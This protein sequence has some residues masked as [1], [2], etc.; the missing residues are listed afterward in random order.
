MR[1][2]KAAIPL[3]FAWSSPFVRW[4]GVLSEMSSLDLAVDVTRRALEDRGLAPEGIEKLVLGWTVPQP[5]IFYGAPTVAARIGAE[6]VSGPMIS[7]ACATS[8]VCVETAAMGVEG[9]DGLTLV[10]ATDRTSNGP[11]L[12]YPRPSAMGGAPLIENWVLDNFARDPWAG[13][14]MIATAEHVAREADLSRQELDE[15]TLLRYQQYRRSLDRERAFQRRYLVPVAVPAGRAG[16][17]M[18]EADEGVH[19]TTAEGL[20]AL[21]PVQPEGV[22]TYGS[23]THPAD[24][25]AGCIVTTVERARELS[26]GEGVAR[27]LGSGLARVEKARMPKAPVPA[28]ERAL[29]DAGLTMADVDV[30]TTHN[31]FAVNDLWFAR[32]TGYPLERMNPYGCSLVYGHPQGPTGL[33]L[34]AELIETLRERG[35]GVGLFTGCAAGDTGAALV[36]RV[37]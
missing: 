34:I 26:G 16:V 9:G 24:G 8:A 3:G 14:A 30:V 15:V 2:E 25:C 13:E 11:V 18:V 32:Q 6:G 7:Q 23:Q 36:L 12:S 17:R 4:Q 31:P 28:A 20:A 27:I 37:E 35:G 1:F 10:V 19:E 33:R 22:I 21:R 29:A 5:G